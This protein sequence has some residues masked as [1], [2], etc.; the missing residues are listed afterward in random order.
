ML[1]LLLP[2]A[3]Q[4]S[5]G[6]RWQFENDGEDT[7]DWDQDGNPGELVNQAAFG[8]VTPLQEGSFYLNL[9]PALANDYFQ[10]ADHGDLDFQDEDIAISM[11]IYPLGF[12]DTQFLVTKGTQNI[13]PKTTN[14]ALRLESSTGNLSFLIRDAAN[15]AQVATSRL[16]VPAETWTFVAAYYD[17]ASQQVFFWDTTTASPSDTLAFAQSFFPNDGPLAV[18]CWYT[19]DGQG[20]KHFNGRIDDLRISSN[21]Q[22]V[23]P[24]ALAI[25][26]A[27][28]ARR[29]ARDDLA[30]G[31]YPNPLSLSGGRQGLT[32]R[33]EAVYEP[34]TIAIYN[35]LG[36]EVYRK[37]VLTRGPETHM[38][39][40]L[41]QLTGNRIST[42]V[43]L[44]TRQSPS[45][46][47]V[48]RFTLL[49]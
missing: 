17:F 28:G 30:L 13:N 6:G 40:H 16:A 31:L 9:D 22:D 10:V 20:V 4:T 37:V 33:L 41:N 39:W 38:Q 24:E 26:A 14:Y 25:I 46:L 23:L 35:L 29:G 34:T 19:T 18:G 42:G 5:K 27:G 43:Y 45:G 21:L 8:D 47:A 3:G 2:L 11:W 44:I 7:A 12:T 15:Q 36:Q 48:K 49:K 1:T 32:I